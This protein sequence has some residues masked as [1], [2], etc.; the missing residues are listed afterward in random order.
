MPKIESLKTS[1]L[2]L[3][4]MELL[5]LVRETRR[6]RDAYIPPKKKPTKGK[7]KKKA[8]EKAAPAKKRA[9]K[10]AFDLSKLT[11]DKAAKLLE[12]LKGRK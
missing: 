12:L 1:I 11:P 9:K 10:E 2:Y 6:Q 3:S 4:R 5:E 7:G 8:T